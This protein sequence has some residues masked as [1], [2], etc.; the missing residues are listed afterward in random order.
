MSLPKVISKN[1][2]C[3]CI[4]LAKIYT[5]FAYACIANVYENGCGNCN[6]DQKDININGL[7]QTET[8]KYT[9]KEL[10]NSYGWKSDINS[11]L[12]DQEK[13]KIHFIELLQRPSSGEKIDRG[14]CSNDID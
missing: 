2:P 3:G 13:E 11:R 9:W 8:E 5:S 12:S 10:M 1:L 7:W 14:T 6:E 4:V